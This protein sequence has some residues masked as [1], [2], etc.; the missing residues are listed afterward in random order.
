MNDWIWL[1]GFLCAMF[2]IVMFV[3]GY[4]NYH[5]GRGKELTVN[6]RGRSLEEM[7]LEGLEVVD[8]DGR[9]V[10]TIDG[11][12]VNR[13]ETIR[14]AIERGLPPGHAIRF[15]PNTPQSAPADQPLDRP[16]PSR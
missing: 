5:Y 4:L 7:G 9:L 14:E 2:L 6:V 13:G 11:L 15:S 10:G 16:L 8:Q 1:F 12:V 3:R